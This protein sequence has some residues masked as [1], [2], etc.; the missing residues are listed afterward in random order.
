M[1]PKTVTRVLDTGALMRFGVG[2]REM[3]RGVAMR[4]AYG[5]RFEGK[6]ASRAPCRATE[7]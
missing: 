6:V 1:K 2:L 5:R 7:G 4:A 3:Y